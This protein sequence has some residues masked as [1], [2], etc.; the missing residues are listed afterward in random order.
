MAPSRKIAYTTTSSTAGVRFQGRWEIEGRSTRSYQPITY[1]PCIPL[2]NP[3]N[4]TQLETRNEMCKMAKF[5]KFR[6]KIYTIWYSRSFNSGSTGAC[7]HHQICSPT[8]IYNLPKSDPRFED[9]SLQLIFFSNKVECITV[10]CSA[11]TWQMVNQMN[12]HRHHNQILPIKLPLQ[13]KRLEFRSP[14]PQR[15]VRK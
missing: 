10:Y 2:T 7:S 12:K 8:I 3:T 9:A 14:I 15:Q 4:V 11:V 5:V 13:R 6:S 1:S